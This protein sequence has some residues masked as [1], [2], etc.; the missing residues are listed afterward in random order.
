[1]GFIK[2]NFTISDS[3]FLSGLDS[4]ADKFLEREV[5]IK[6]PKREIVKRQP[7]F[8]KVSNL[9]LN[10]KIKVDDNSETRDI[11]ESFGI[12]VQEINENIFQDVSF[13]AREANII[14][15][16]GTSGSG[17]SLLLKTI[18]K[19]THS[20]KTEI[21]GG[22]VDYNGSIY[23]PRIDDFESPVLS[24]FLKKYPKQNVLAT[25]ARCGLGE[26]FLFLRKINQLSNGQYYRSLLCDLVLKNSDIW[27]LDEFCANLDPITAKI[28]TK[29]LRSLVIL[30]SK[31]ALIAAAHS[32][33]FLDVLKPTFSIVLKKGKKPEV[34][35]KILS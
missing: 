24:Y 22:I 23:E 13:Y 14:F 16:T 11:I 12:T 9:S 26:P 25:L 6:K 3:I 29:N 19:N 20:E 27:I 35:Q 15:I 8:L 2:K 34:T 4:E 1:M 10:S 17:K 5:A 7:C 28:I 21:E 18:S 32:H 33:H 31:I 30:N